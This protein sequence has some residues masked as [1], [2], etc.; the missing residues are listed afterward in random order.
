MAD[1]PRLTLQETAVIL[2]EHGFPG[3]ANTIADRIASGHY[4]F[5]QIVSVGATNRRT[6]VI[7]R[8]DLLRWIQEKT[9]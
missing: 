4:S 6:F 2:R 8:A 9:V 1:K 7:Y 3:C 5:G